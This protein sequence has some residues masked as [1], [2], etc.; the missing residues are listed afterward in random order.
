MNDAATTVEDVWHT[1]SDGLRAFLRA[2]LPNDSD[3]D[4]LLHDVF[5]RVHEKI[6][7]LRQSERIEAW[8][9]QIGRNALADFYRRRSPRL[10]DAVEDVVD[11]H[12]D[13]DYKKNKNLAVAAWLPLMIDVLPQTLRD[14][15]RMY[16]IEGVSQA[17]IA[18]RLGISLSGAKSRVQRG[19]RRLEEILRGSCDFQLDRRG[20]IIAC[21][22]ANDDDCGQASC[23]CDD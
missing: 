11:P 17:E 9:Y 6:G 22:P 5:V 3:A 14:A 20:N 16:E 12:C 19:R 15:V 4:D 13:D 21:K 1:I 18:S 10:A 23:E 7:S 8:V 2:R